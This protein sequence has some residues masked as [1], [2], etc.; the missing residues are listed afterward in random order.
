M[1][2]RVRNSQLCRDP[3]ME[4]FMRGLLFVMINPSPGL[5]E[6]SQATRIAGMIRGFPPPL[7]LSLV[8]LLDIE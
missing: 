5:D 3:T 6:T 8:R 4:E 2:V 1:L 7:T